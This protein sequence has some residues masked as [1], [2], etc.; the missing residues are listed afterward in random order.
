M[1]NRFPDMVLTV[2]WLDYEGKR[3]VYGALPAG[4][5]TFT[6]GTY[7][8]HPWIIANPDGNCLVLFDVPVAATKAR[9]FD[10]SLGP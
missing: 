9:P 2:Y 10:V 1:T 5:E 7:L 4:G 6:Q 3:I 8:T